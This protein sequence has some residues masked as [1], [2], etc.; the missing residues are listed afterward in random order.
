MWAALVIDR[1]PVP[2][3]LV[4]EGKGGGSVW[5]GRRFPESAAF[6]AT[7]LPGPPPQGG[8]EIAAPAPALA[9]G[10]S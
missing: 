10:A 5:L 1:R 7:P 4:G 8:R 6:A 9:A 3:P 2:S